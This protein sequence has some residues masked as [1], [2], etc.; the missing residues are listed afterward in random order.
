MLSG[1][2]ALTALLNTWRGDTRTAPF[3]A[4]LYTWTL[5]SG[6]VI[7]WTGADRDIVWNGNT[8]T[9]GPG[10]TRSQISRQV[11]TQTSD[12]SI[13]LYY[14]DTTLQDGIPLAQ[15]IAGGGFLNATLLFERAYA[16]SPG[17]PI[18][19]TLP[20][21]TGR[22]TQLQKTGESQATL[23]VSTWMSLLN[24][25]V[26]VNQWQPP[27]LHILFGPGCGLDRTNPAYNSTGIIQSGSDTLNI[28][29]DL[30]SKRD[31]G[32]MNLGTISLTSGANAGQSRT[33]KTQTGGVV[34]LV[35]SLPTP[36]VAGDTYIAYVGCDL[37]QPRCVFLQNQQ[38]FK[39]QRWIPLAITAAP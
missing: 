7:R 9:R 5:S 10:I 35:R 8:Y 23:V 24:V 1:T 31:D 13:T 16:P 20:K 39:G 4:E 29:T 36:P 28:F 33:I 27:C 34:S 30:G 14:S 3:I 12:L 15:F 25:Q 6:A 22:M 26:P 2:P 19:G 17:A 32:E 18:V 21:F 38:H 37:T 11:G